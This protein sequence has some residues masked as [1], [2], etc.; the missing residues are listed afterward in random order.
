MSEASNQ[1]PDNE[2]R[3]PGV[4]QIIGSIL[5][6]ALGV[7]SDQNRKRDFTQGNPLVYIFGGIIFTVLFVLTLVGVVMLVLR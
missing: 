5:S 6:A 1:S 4:F 2:P 3:K 7:Q